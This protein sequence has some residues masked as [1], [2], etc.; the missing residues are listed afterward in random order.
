MKYAHKT[1]GK[2][3]RVGR[4]GKVVHLNVPMCVTQRF[5]R[6]KLCFLFL[7]RITLSVWKKNFFGLSTLSIRRPTFLNILFRFSSGYAILSLSPF[8]CE[9]LGIIN[10][11]W[12]RRTTQHVTHNRVYY[13]L[14]DWSVRNFFFFSFLLIFFL[15]PTSVFPFTLLTGRLARF[16]VSVCCNV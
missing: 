8:V 15:L 16:L 10:F 9:S 4:D 13:Y 1:N 12:R 2:R 11:V 5:C 7:K 14:L 3:E 6:I